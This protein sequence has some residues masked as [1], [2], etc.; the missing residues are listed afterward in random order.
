MILEFLDRLARTKN[1]TSVLSEKRYVDK[2]L[3][4]NIIHRLD[5]LIYGGVSIGFLDNINSFFNKEYDW[6][7]SYKISAKHSELESQI[8]SPLTLVSPQFKRP[9]ID[10]FVKGL[11]YKDSFS[12]SFQLVYNYGELDVTHERATT[13]GV[14]FNLPI[15]SAYS[16]EI[17]IPLA[18]E[19]GHLFCLINEQ[20]L[21]N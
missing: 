7:I 17:W 6:N 20:N 8:F 14:V 4:E 12:I 1:Y 5:E 19:I 21:I 16:P 10:Y 18:H 3:L 11:G 15:I 2:N 9:E 13:G